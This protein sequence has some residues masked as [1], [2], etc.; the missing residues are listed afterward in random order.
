MKELNDKDFDQIFKKRIADGYLEYEEESWLKMEQKLRKRDRFVFLRNASIILLFLSFG[1]GIYLINNETSVNKEVKTVKA[2]KKAIETDKMKTDDVLTEN[3]PKSTPLL[4]IV[5][6]R[7][8]LNSE[9]NTVVAKGEFLSKSETS[10]T[11]QLTPQVDHVSPTPPIQESI[12]LQSVETVIEETTNTPRKQKRPIALSILV[13]PDFNSTENTI[14]GK[15][16]MA[17]G[18]A[19]SIP[20]GKKL[21]IQTGVNYGSKNYEAQGYDYAFNNPNTANVIAGIDAACKVLEIPLRASYTVMNNQKNSIDLNAG[22]SSYIM[23]KENYRFIYTAASARNDRFLEKNNANQH[24]LSVIDLSAS[25]NIKLKNKKF[26]L[27]LQPYLKIP[28]SGIGEGN[29]PLK[30]SGISLKL[31]YEFNK[32]K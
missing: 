15:S 1:L 21:S 2:T 31:N 9:V 22:L 24:Y 4:S 16:G 18:I 13:G 27:G 14:G 8:H 6:K 3:Q 12:P 10:T 28:I 7:N 19:I 30:S 29:V 23:L 25:Y 32:K 20:I 5:K 11:N 17:V 26:A